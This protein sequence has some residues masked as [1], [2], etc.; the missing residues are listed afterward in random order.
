MLLSIDKGFE[1]NSNEEQ[2]CKIIDTTSKL[3]LL[4]SNKYCLKKSLHIH[5]NRID[6]LI[7]YKK[8]HLIHP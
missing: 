7:P 5:K 2:N 6:L 3:I 1:P 8:F 4:F